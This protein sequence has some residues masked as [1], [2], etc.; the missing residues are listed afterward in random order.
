MANNNATFVSTGKPNITGAIFRAPLGTPLPT[1]ADDVLDSAFVCL[2]YASEDGVENTNEMTVSEIKAW[3][4]MIVY[5]SLDGLTDNFGFKLIESENIEVLKTVYGTNNVTEDASGNVSVAVK[6]EDPEEGVWVFLMAMR[7][8]VK[9]MIVIKDGAIT[10]RE[11]ITY[12][13]SDPVAYGVTVSAYPDADGKTH[14]EFFKGL[15]S[16]ASI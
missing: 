16:P 5:R 4:G 8:N 15:T 11:A 14:D 10:A 12:N 7:G 2:G 13:D 6:A 3:G 9:K 1:K